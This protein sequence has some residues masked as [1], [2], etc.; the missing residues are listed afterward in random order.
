MRDPQNVAWL[1]DIKKTVF[2]TIEVER[3]RARMRMIS[4]T[5]CFWCAPGRPEDAGNVRVRER[6][7]AKYG[8]GRAA[9]TEASNETGQGRA[10]V[11]LG[12][13]RHGVSR[14]MVP[15]AEKWASSAPPA[16][17]CHRRCA[18][19]EPYAVCR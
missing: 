8:S 9:P 14:L 19:A 1:L 13:R 10:G 5:R 4:G 16:K 17:R 6:R 11:P 3:T 15:L 2:E 7:C 18:S 12:L